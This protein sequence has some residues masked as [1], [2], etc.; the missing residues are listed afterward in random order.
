MAV[1]ET[2]ELDE[3]LQ[4]AQAQLKSSQANLDLAKITSKTCDLAI[5]WMQR[6]QLFQLR[7]VDLYSLASFSHFSGVPLASGLSAPPFCLA[8][9]T[10]PPGSFESQSSTV[11]LCAVSE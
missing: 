6:R 2:P 1:I 10:T 3:Q 5:S 8:N 11:N 9:R 7:Q 4:V